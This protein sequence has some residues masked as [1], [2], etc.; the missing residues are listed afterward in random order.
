MSDMS[1][2]MIILLAEACVILL[3]TLIVVLW[4]QIKSKNKQRKAVEQ[5]VSQ[6]KKQ[7]K[8]RTEETG[9]F[10]QE[11]YD[12]SDTE[13]TVAVKAIDKQERR[14]FQKLVDVLS[15]SEPGQITALDA[16]VAEL[17]DTYKSLKLKPVE[18][19]TKPSKADDNTDDLETLRAENA[20]LTEELKI[21][22]ETM[23][24]MISEFGNMF[25][26]GEDNDLDS[27]EVANRFA[28]S[29]ANPEGGEAVDAPSEEN[30]SEAVKKVDLP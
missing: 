1:S 10:L 22:R 28:T 27:N 8:T 16:S 5:L 30:T 11:A 23:S 4:H 18:A 15:R 25:G 7:S 3:V 29:V 2:L 6:I 9:S 21:T 14:F 26:G 13:L 20:S 19:I 17:V 12:L 24:G